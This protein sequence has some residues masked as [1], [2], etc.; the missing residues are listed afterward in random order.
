MKKRIMITAVCAVIVMGLTMPLAAQTQGNRIEFDLG[1]LE[2]NTLKATAGLFTNDIDDFMSVHD[3]DGVLSSENKWFGFLSGKNMAGGVIDVGYARIFGGIYVGAWY[4]GNVFRTGGSGDYETK[5]VTP[6]YD[7]DLEILNSKTET[8]SFKDA[9]NESTNNIE[10]LIGVKGMG[11][12]VGF[13]ESTSTNKN[14]GPAEWNFEDT[15]GDGIADSWVPRSITVTDYMDGQKEY[16]NAVDVYTNSQTYLKPYAGW[17]G[18]FTVAGMDISPF[19]NIGFGMYGDKLIYKYRNYTEV[20]GEEQDVQTFIS[21]G[22]NNGYMEPYGEV[23]A[24]LDLPQKRSAAAMSVGI[25]Y[26]FNMRLYKNSADGLGSVGGT[27]NW[28]S[29][30]IDLETE[31]IDRT[32]TETNMTYNINEKSY[33]GHTIVPSYKITGEPAENFKLGFTAEVPIRIISESSN[34]YD[35]QIQKEVTKYDWDI[36]GTVRERERTTYYGKDKT[37]TLGIDLNLAIGASYQLVPGRF[38]I[39]AGISASPIR[40]EH[41]VVRTIPSSTYSVTTTKETQDD[42]SVTVNDKTVTLTPNPEDKV[43]ITDIWNQYTAQLGGGFTFN[44]TPK[45]AL[46]LAVSGGSYSDND[47]NLNLTTLNVIFTFKF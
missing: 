19:A 14:K 22:H 37:S 44:F 3:Y 39:N 42:G 34:N 1:D 7:D 20:N 28:G 18:S 15:D 12:K 21:N 38:G 31:Y 29:G 32:I 46:D 8:T 27:V 11:I 47:F 33:M 26:G 16:T 6:D 36:P 9:W 2:S 4:R 13:F 30:Y 40:Y 10:F 41:T 45:I 43:E 25:S 17:G 35:K 23:G 24:Y 5:T